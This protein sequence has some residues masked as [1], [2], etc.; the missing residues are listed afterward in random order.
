MTVT[1]FSKAT[2]QRLSNE[3]LL[4]RQS[5]PGHPRLVRYLPDEVL[6]LLDSCRPSAGAGTSGAALP[7]LAATASRR[8]ARPRPPK[9]H[10]AGSQTHSAATTWRAYLP[11][12]G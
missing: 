5:P 4:T 11:A 12:N 10:A 1:S 3:G 9:R 8:A 2:I 6:T 7:P